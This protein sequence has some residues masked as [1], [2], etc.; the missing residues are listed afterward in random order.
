MKQ[1]FIFA[2]TAAGEQA[3]A[4]TTPLEPRNR[5]FLGLVDGR[6]AVAELA[7]V[8]R[9]DELLPTL[10]ALLD[11]GFIEKIDENRM[12]MSGIEEETSDPFAAAAM[13][14][15]MFERLKRRAVADLT[16]RIG[17]AGEAVGQRIQG[18]T[19]PAELRQALRASGD[20]LAA[21]MGVAPAQEFLQ[22]LGRNLVA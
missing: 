3:L 20:E 12:V 8:S 21:L 11:A 7:T 14:P 15:Q 10:Q 18:A 5:R 17:P 13:T 16:Q 6:R 1:H 19:T 22:A 2:R 4:G 9:P